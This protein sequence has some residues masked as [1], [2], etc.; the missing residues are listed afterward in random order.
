MQDFDQ[1]NQRKAELIAQ[2]D[3]IN[4]EIVSIQKQ[5]A[6]AARQKINDI[7]KSTGLSAEELGLGKAATKL[8]GLKGTKVAARYRDDAT[9]K[10]WSGRGRR[11]AWIGDDLTKFEIKQ[12]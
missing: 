12:N 5:C 7:I 9:G 6:D 4:T 10:E 11:P 1:L 3:A 8:H 2:R